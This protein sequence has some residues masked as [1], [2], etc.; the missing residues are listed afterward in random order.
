VIRKPREATDLMMW[1]GS[2]YYPRIEDFVEEAERVGVS[3]RIAY[4][5]VNIKL[6]RS[7]LFLTHDDSRRSDCKVCRGTGTKDGHLRVCLY[8]KGGASKTLRDPSNNELV[9]KSKRAFQQ[10]NK[11]TAKQTRRK[12]TWRRIRGQPKC[13]TCSGLGRVAEG[14]IF[15]FCRIDRVE[16]L[17]DR[18]SAAREYQERQPPKRRRAVEITAVVSMG[19]QEVARGCGYRQIGAHYLIADKLDVVQEVETISDQLG[20]NW[21]LR[22]SIVV[23]DKP[24]PYT[25]QRFRGTKAVNRTD[26]FGELRKRVSRGRPKQRATKR[27]RK[28]RA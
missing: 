12:K 1:V 16:L 15:G 8:V 9:V 28:A 6:G 18:S 14:V 23:F 7:F 20:M 5:P 27:N 3:K 4:P 25:G 13:V 22:G 19:L 17:F 10:L 26:I 2:S 21:T 11:K 24:V